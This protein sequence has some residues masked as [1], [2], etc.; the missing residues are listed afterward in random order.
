LLEQGVTVLPDI[1]VNAGGVIVSYF[2]WAQNLQQF[3]WTEKAVNDEL[4]K[5]IIKAY[6]EVSSRVLAEAVTH[7]EAA[8]DIGVER[9]A[10]AVTLRG[11]V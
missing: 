6:N 10:K 3:H 4:K 2:E 8:F 1:L 11:F 9:V 7:R 5:K